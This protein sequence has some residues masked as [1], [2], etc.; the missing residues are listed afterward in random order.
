MTLASEKPFPRQ[1]K[2]V[3]G[4]Y[5]APG[6]P[7]NS[8]F[9]SNRVEVIVLWNVLHG[10]RRPIVGTERVG[11]TFCKG[12]KLEGARDQWP[13]VWHVGHNHGGGNLACVPVEVDQGAN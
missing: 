2:L 8:V 3:L 6:T 1:I 13:K 4:I 10:K 5:K 12:T 7:S 9:A 11:G